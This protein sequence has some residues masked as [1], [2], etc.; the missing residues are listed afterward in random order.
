MRIQARPEPV[1]L[2]PTRTALL[3][4]DMQNAF[5]SPGG[6][7]DQVG[8]PI[9][10]IQEAIAPTRTAVE[11]ARKAG[12]KIIYLKM[13]FQADLSDLGTNGGAQDRFFAHMGIPDGVLTRDEW[14]SDIVDELTPS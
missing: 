4:V 11:A 5:G 7:F 13:G 1:D 3:V 8:V 2:D 6:M 10:S 14:G 9:D 12:L